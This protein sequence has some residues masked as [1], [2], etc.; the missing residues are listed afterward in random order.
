MFLTLIT[1]AL[2]HARQLYREEPIPGR[3]SE[4]PPSAASGRR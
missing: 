1:T 3:R 2:V 4:A